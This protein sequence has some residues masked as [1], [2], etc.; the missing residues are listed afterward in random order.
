MLDLNL[1]QLNFGK[2]Y[3]FT[4]NI[5]SMNEATG[6]ALETIQ[7]HSVSSNGNSGLQENGDSVTSSPEI[8]FVSDWR[9]R[10][11]SYACQLAIQS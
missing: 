7:R 10:T 1:L 3:V 5:T 4:Y 2:K 6:M 11:T 8:T 9:T